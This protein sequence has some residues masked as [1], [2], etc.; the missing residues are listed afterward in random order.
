MA[1]RIESGSGSAV[2]WPA[3]TLPR[4][5]G[6][7]D[8]AAAEGG[9]GADAGVPPTYCAHAGAPPALNITAHTASKSARLNG[10]SSA[11][12]F[13]KSSSS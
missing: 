12:A 10:P 3:G 13:A 9:E 2:G 1:S 5:V 6:A 11:P 4:K 7:M 8:L